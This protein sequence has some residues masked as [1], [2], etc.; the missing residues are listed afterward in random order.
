LK[1]NADNGLASETL[2]QYQ[3]N[4]TVNLSLVYVQITFLGPFLGC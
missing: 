1:Q 4:G 2:L 3:Q